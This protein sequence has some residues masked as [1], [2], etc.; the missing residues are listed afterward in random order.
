MIRFSH[1]AEAAKIDIL[2]KKVAAAIKAKGG[3]IYQIGGAVR[4]ELLGKVSK[5]LDL[6][7]VGL[8]MSELEKLLSDYGT[9]NMVGKSFGVVKFTPKGSKPP[10]EYS[11]P[12]IKFEPKGVAT[13]RGRQPTE[14][15]DAA[16]RPRD[17]AWLPIM[18]RY[19]PLENSALST[20]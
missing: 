8:D 20:L 9:A 19:F 16:T 3:K 6:L 12:N 2:P 4:D 13:A 17:N 15:T 18:F 1:F 5:D 14:F 11:Y 7:V 10:P